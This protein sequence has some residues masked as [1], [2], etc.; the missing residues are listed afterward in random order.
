MTLRLSG[1]LSPVGILSM[2]MVSLVASG[3]RPGERAPQIGL[4]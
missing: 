1:G 4:E 2:R 3:R